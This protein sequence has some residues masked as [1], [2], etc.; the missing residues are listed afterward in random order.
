MRRIDKLKTQGPPGIIG[1]SVC[2]R[3]IETR[4]GAKRPPRRE[5]RPGTLE[6]RVQ[7]EYN[8]ALRAV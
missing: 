1:I 7:E 5:A 6:T 2:P 4:A 3:R 8:R